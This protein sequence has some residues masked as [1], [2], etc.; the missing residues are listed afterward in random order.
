MAFLLNVEFSNYI[1]IFRYSSQKTMN[2][3]TPPPSPFFFISSWILFDYIGIWE[4][5]R[6]LALVFCH[7]H[8]VAIPRLALLCHRQWSVF[9]LQ[10]PDDFALVSVCA[11]QYLWMVCSLLTI[12]GIGRFDKTGGSSLS[13]SKISIQIF[14]LWPLI[15]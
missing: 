1:Y 11:R 6:A 7:I 5:N 2:S 12:P 3:H 14:N 13:S 9:C 8:N 10:H 15:G 4:E